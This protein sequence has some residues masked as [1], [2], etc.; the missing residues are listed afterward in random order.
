MRRSFGKILYCLSITIFLSCLG[1]GEGLSQPAQEGPLVRLGNVTFQKREIETV[2]FTLEVLE[3]QIEVLNQSQQSVAPPNSIKV[4]VVPKEVKSPDG[5]PVNAFAPA[6]GEATLD[7]PLP[8]RTG[9]VL[10][11]GF[12]IPKEKLGSIVFEVQ[13][14]PPEG[15]KKLVTWSGK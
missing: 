2:S 13:I 12:A 14:N 8:P 7:V 1:A 4:V 9:R 11:I 3:V 5:T 6:S 10:I 15:E